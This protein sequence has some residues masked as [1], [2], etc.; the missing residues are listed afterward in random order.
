LILR[1]LIMAMEH[2][3]LLRSQ[4]LTQI[5]VDPAL[6]G[7]PVTVTA[8]VEKPR[9]VKPPKMKLKAARLGGLF[10][11]LA[12]RIAANIAKLPELLR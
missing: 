2:R 12:R 1:K 6:N 10:P 9:A 3:E 4:N 5:N 7:F 11:T 8:L